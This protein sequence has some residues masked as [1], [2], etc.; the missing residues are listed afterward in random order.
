MGQF[1]L[2][3]KKNKNKKIRKNISLKINI[4]FGFL[5]AVRGLAGLNDTIKFLFMLV[6]SQ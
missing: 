6:T 2:Y 4:L 5:Y 1:V 3:I